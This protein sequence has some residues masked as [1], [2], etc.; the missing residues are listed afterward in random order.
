VREHDA[1]LIT[2]VG[3][4]LLTTEARPQTQGTGLIR[5]SRRTTATDGITGF[6]GLPWDFNH[7]HSAEHRR[8]G[9]DRRRDSPEAWESAAT[10][11]ELGLELR[12]A[13][14]AAA[15]ATID[16]S[17]IESNLARHRA[18]AQLRAAAGTSV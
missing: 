18:I 5:R 11:V 13:M 2:A 7:E 12:R 1:S 3:G 15:G 16:V 17:G 4:D 10:L 9:W 8:C 6:G 14:A